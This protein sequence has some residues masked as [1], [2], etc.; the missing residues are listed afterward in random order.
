MSQYIIKKIKIESLFGLYSYTLNNID[1]SDGTIILY[2]DNGVGKS[3]I[4]RMVFDLLSIS[5]E[6]GHRSAILKTNFKKIEVTL[7]SG[8]ILS[9]EKKTSE[10]SHEVLSLKIIEDNKEVALWNYSTEKTHVR[11]ITVN[12]KRMYVNIN[13]NYELEYFKSKNPNHSES[14][15][16]SVYGESI[17]MAKLREVV[18]TTFILNADRRLDG[19]SISDGDDEVEYRRTMRY[20]EP[21]SIQD[22]V[23]RSREIALTQALFAA[24]KWI[25]RKAVIG[26]NQGTDNVHSTYIR[27]LKHIVSPKNDVSSE[28][29]NDELQKLSA[30]IESLG[31]E[32]KRLAKYELTTALDMTEFSRVLQFQENTNSSLSID[33]LKPYIESLDVRLEAVRSIYITIDRFITI[34][35]EL[36]TDKEMG[37]HLSQGFYIK[38]K[39]KETLTSAQLSS[40]E[41]QLLLLFCNV[42]VARDK[43]SLFI[44]DEPEISLN[45]KWQRKLIHYLLDITQDTSVQFMFASHSLEIISQH[46]HRVVKLVNEHE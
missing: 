38:N 6:K 8:V 43:P 46:R 5:D 29:A 18:P 10:S 36:L 4:L 39:F 1:I 20:G 37:F 45:I 16:L 19:D 2:G 35:N 34:V 15:K 26:T 7:E 41:Q 25:S 28:I 14:K 24:S 3:T 17:Y 11:E 31:A 27:I 23:I 30:K 42:L 9:A 12:N 13:E 22:L 40:G 33:L 32:T 21:K 44:I